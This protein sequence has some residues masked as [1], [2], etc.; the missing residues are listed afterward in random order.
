M[1]RRILICGSRDW[2]DHFPIM[3]LIRGVADGQTTIVHGGARGAD[4][5]AAGVAR[6]LG[7]PDEPHFADWKGHGRAAGPIRNEE[8]LASGV[9]EV[10][11][12]KDRFDWSLQRGGTE[13]MVRIARDAGLPVYVVS[14]VRVPVGVHPEAPQP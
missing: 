5:M 10:W 3:R 14:S 7:V 13:H 6:T 11:A 9:N 8:M 1:S 12:F 2:T 4:E